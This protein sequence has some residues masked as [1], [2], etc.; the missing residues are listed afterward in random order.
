MTAVRR[1]PA[2]PNCA[3][4]KD[5]FPWGA[6]IPTLTAWYTARRRDLPWRK[7]SDPYSVWV[8]EVMLQQTRVETVLAYYE[9]FLRRFPH[10]ETLASASPDEVL[11]SW[12]GLGY[13]ARARN[14]WAGSRVLLKGGEW[15]RTVDSLERIP[16]IGRSTAGA[17]AS[18]AFGVRAPIL[19]GNVKR[20]WCRIFGVREPWKPDALRFLWGLS[21]AAVRRGPPGEI[22]QALMELGAVVCRPRAPSCESCPVEPDCFARAVGTREAYPGRRTRAAIPSREAVAALLWRGERF[23][24][25]RRPDTG[26]LGGLWELPGGRV[27]VKEPRRAALH[28]EMMEELGLRVA[29][30][31]EEPPVRH[32]Y[33]HFKVRLWA[34]HCL[35]LR[36]GE[37]PV[38]ERPFRWIRPEEIS[39]L[40]FP[41]ATLKVFRGIRERCPPKMRAAEEAAAWRAFG[42]SRET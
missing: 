26:L 14:L 17:V 21:E 24:V 42:R 33:S 19:D 32:A 28:R 25:T 5:P 15:P 16:G 27:E 12:E 11:K 29:V 3:E 22:N 23:L 31:G 7:T 34:Y 20:V 18:I 1:I 41:A 8:S 37:D 2:D 4:R 6:S 38:T 13:Y 40:A 10:L 30:V 39:G 9:P 35:P 36:T